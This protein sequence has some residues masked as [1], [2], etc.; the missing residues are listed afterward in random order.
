MRAWLRSARPVLVATALAAVVATAPAALAQHGQHAR[1]APTPAPTVVLGKLDFPTSTRVPAAQAAFEEGMLLLHLFEYRPAMLAFRRAQALDPGFA[2]AYWGEAM[3][4]THPVWN[5]QDLPAARAALAKLGPTPEARAAKAGTPVERE[6][7]HLAEVL[8]GEG[9]KAERDL[10]LLAATEAMAARHPDN[11]EAQLQLS[12]ALLGANQGVRDL[13]RFLRAA[14]VAK[15]VFRRNPKHPGAAHYWIHGMDD[16]VNAAGALEA[17]RALSVIAP[18]AGHSLHM[19][20]HIFIALGMWDDVVS[21]NV[22][23]L[24]VVNEQLARKDQPPTSCGHYPEW[25][26]Y[27]Y[28]QQGREQDARTLLD[29]CEASGEPGLAWMRAHPG[30]VYLGAAT[31]AVRKAANDGALMRMRAMVLVDSP[32]HRGAVAARPLDPVALGRDA[33]GVLLGRGLAE[34]AAGDRAAAEATLAA[35]RAVAALPDG[36]DDNGVYKAH[37][38]V[39]AELLDA[40]IA[41]AAGRQ[42]DALRIARAAA[43][44]LDAMPFDFGPPATV[45]PPRELLGE[46]LLRAGDKAGALAAFEAA[47]KA[48]PKRRFAEAGRAAALA[49]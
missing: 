5:Q 6:F 37:L 33:G 34:A 18:D 10:A 39:M 22:A 24:R 40:R 42:D 17:A 13:P 9:S 47:L 12:L 26:L 36:P 48:A 29:A 25:L 4:H 11:D 45:K 14:D 41:E 27:A 20:S 15:A 49:P 23:A 38:A 32:E 2:M 8:Y 21:S 16:P 30:E 43:D 31:P 19:T 35:L 7:L 46:M 28:L 1:H 3:T 44:R